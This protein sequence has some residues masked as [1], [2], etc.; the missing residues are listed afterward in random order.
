MATA[1]LLL[2][3]NA[4]QTVLVEVVDAHDA[5]AAETGECPDDDEGRCDCG[6]NCHCCLACAHHG[7]QTTPHA[8]ALTVPT[9]LDEQTIVLGSPS[10]LATQD[11]R[12]PPP[13][14]PRASA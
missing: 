11:E 13:K 2:G 12:G 9:Y 14:V 1:Y 4:W 8:T 5:H 6:P 3:I 10:D 7:T